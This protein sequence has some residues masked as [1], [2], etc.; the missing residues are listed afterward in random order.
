MAFDFVEERKLNCVRIIC[1]FDPAVDK[2]AME[3]SDILEQYEDDPIKNEGLLKFKP[4]Q[5]PTVFIC[6]FDLKGSE[7]AYIKDSMSKMDRDK[8]PALAYGSWEYTTVRVVLKEIENPG[9]LKFKKDSKGYVDEFTM[10]QLEKFGIVS[11]IFGVYNKLTKPEM[12][13]NAKN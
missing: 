5:A 12:R 1:P 6:N 3:G 8:Q 9:K 7:S 10:G 11:H 2:E 4:G 13:A